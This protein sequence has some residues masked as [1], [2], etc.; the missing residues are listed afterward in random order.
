M[1]VGAG[2]AEARD[3][4]LILVIS[5]AVCA[6][7]CIAVIIGACCVSAAQGEGDGWSKGDVVS[8][9]EDEAV[10]PAAA[11]APQAPTPA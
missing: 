6:W 3:V 10:T 7:L 2:C 1:Q 4:S 5:I 8:P 11:V 9:H